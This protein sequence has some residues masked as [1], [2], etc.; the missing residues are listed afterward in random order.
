MDIYINIKQC[1][2][3]VDAIMSLC[4]LKT[5]DLSWQDHSINIEVILAP[6]KTDLLSKQHRSLGSKCDDEVTRYELKQ[7]SFLK[8]LQLEKRHIGQKATEFYV[9]KARRF[10]D[11]FPVDLRK[12]I[13][14]RRSFSVALN[15]IRDEVVENQN[16]AK[17]EPV[18]SSSTGSSPRKP[19]IGPGLL[20]QLEN[21]SN[22]IQTRAT[23]DF[24]LTEV[25]EQL[26]N[27]NDELPPVVVEMDKGRPGK[28]SLRR[29]N[30]EY[31]STTRGSS[32]GGTRP[33]LN[34]QKSVRFEKDGDTIK[35]ASLHDKVREFIKEQEYFNSQV[36]QHHRQNRKGDDDDENDKEKLMSAF[37]SFCKSQNNS[38]TH[39]HKLVKLASKFKVS[40]S[41]TNSADHFKSS[42]SFQAIHAK[43]D[44]PAYK[45]PVS[46]NED[47]S[48]LKLS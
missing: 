48:K 46:I 36:Q 6:R 10:L 27:R 33:K 17:S 14:N 4:L 15:R 40:K 18:Q 19:E 24:Y 42:R 11:N 16:R 30:T 29:S 26:Y 34:R 13:L 32:G 47:I 28:P 45:K 25:K 8:H 7:N 44:I 5:R 9:L 31:I 35:K 3:I 37:E 23:D 41:M 12:E 21:K 43:N 22:K 20:P 1:F 38:K 2:I 39:L